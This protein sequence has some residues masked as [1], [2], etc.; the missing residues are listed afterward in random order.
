MENKLKIWLQEIRAP[1][2][3]AAI[4]PILLGTIIAFHEIGQINWV[5]FL[6]T[7][8]GGILLHAGANVA[9]D[10]FDHISQNDEINEEFVRP[11]TGG[12]RIIQ[13]G[14]L[15]PKEV[16]F[17]SLI[18]I[19]IAS[20]IG[21][22]LTYK[23]GIVILMLGLIG[24]VSGFFYTAPPLYW[25]S[26]GIGEIIIGLN[27]GILMTFGAFYVQ[28]GSFSWHPIVASLPVAFL[29][30]AVL[31]INEFQDYKADKAVGK[32]HLVVRLGKQKAV[33]GYILIMFLTYISLVIGVVTDT[34][35]PMSLIGLLTLPL[36]FKSIK[37]ALNFYDDSVKLIP[38]N[39][40]TIMN[41][42]IT[43]LLITVSYVVD[44]F[45]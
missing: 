16:L 42:L 39:A 30:A 6:L 36:A 2:F 20:V 33:F 4:V 31:Y 27:F 37:V 19:F 3:T 26:R 17:G 40:T 1:F 28:A 23:I 18:F 13:Q 21:I 25:V 41:H 5:Y 32:N 24:V 14:L 29:I 43:G 35:P 15:S 45:I 34:L 44:K 10:Y 9:N 22:Y 38:A 12:S 8:I 11:F 7:M